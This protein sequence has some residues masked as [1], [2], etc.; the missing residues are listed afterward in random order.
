[1]MIL[2]IIITAI[3]YLIARRI[4]LAT[5]MPLL[6]P[7]FVAGAM[8]V[9]VIHFTPLSYEAY[10]AGGSLIVRVLGPIVVVLAVPLYKNKEV[11]KKYKRPVFVGVF[12]GIAS[13]LVSVTALV[14]LFNM[15][16][17]ILLSL[18]PKSITNPMAIEVVKMIGGIKE[19]TVIFVAVTGIA[20][21]AICQWVFK[22]F[23]IDNDTAKGIALG[24]A[25]HGV[26][27]AKAVEISD[28]AG[29]AASLSMGISGVVT[30]LIAII[31]VRIFF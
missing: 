23:S 31:V 21:P 6:N 13:S 4:S 25:S 27:T 16:M 15:D 14:K 3:A 8:V 1:M 20:G 12:A 29:A 22:I 7:I 2:G 24:A 11:L 17:D 19:L 18:V 30:I 26:G 10:D 5:R 28:E 9:A